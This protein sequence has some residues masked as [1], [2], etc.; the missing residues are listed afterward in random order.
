MRYSTIFVPLN[1]SL[2]EKR[3]PGGRTVGVSLI[4]KK[5]IGAR[6]KRSLLEEINNNPF[7]LCGHPMQI[8]DIFEAISPPPQFGQPKFPLR[9]GYGFVLVEQP[10]ITI[11]L[12]SLRKIYQY[13]YIVVRGCE[14]NKF[15]D[16]SIL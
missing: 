11:L 2:S 14:I 9:V 16:W 10:I 5:C 8:K 6:K 4:G 12:A 13:N 15:V 7:P 1:L 3:S